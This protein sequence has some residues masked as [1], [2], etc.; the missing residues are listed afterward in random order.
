MNKILKFT[1]DLFD[2]IEIIWERNCTR[3]TVG[4]TLVIAYILSLIVIELKRLGILTGRFAASIPESHFFAINIAFTLLLIF[5]V[6]DLVFGIA[7]SVS[8]A[9]GKQFE[10]FSLILLRMSFKEFAHFHEPLRWQEIYESV[11]PILA[12]AGG[13]LLIF[14]AMV[15]YYRIIHHKESVKDDQEKFSFIA[16]KKA[17]SLLLLLV[18]TIIGILDFRTY[19]ITGNFYPFFHTFYT[20][21]IFTDILIVLI[22]FL[23]THTYQIVFRNS[24]FA[25]ATVIIRLAL[26]APDYYNVALGAG[27]AIFVIG[28]VIAYNKFTPAAD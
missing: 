27:V 12:N 17:I 24:G 20:V 19:L 28:L 21:M 10:I 22:S 16:A 4:L 15:I 23:Y 6:I 2:K 25:L 11:V 14:I 5:E 9:M 1:Y 8:E 18:F 7:R 26:T 13:A 3:R